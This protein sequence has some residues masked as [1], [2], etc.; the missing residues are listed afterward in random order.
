LFFRKDKLKNDF[1]VFKSFEVK[2]K[3]KTFILTVLGGFLL[4]F[5]WFLFMYAVNHVSLQSASFAYLI[6]PIIT[7]ILAFFILKE[8]LSKWQWFSVALCLVSC[9]ILSYGHIQDLAYS[10]IIAST[11][12]LYL[13]SQRKNNQFDRFVVLTVQMVIASLVLL[14]FFPTYKG[15]TPTASLFYILMTLI[16][17]LFTIIPLFLNLY[18][19]KGMNSSTVGILMYTNPLIN[20]ILAIYYFKE[21][22]NTSQMIAYSLILLSIIVFNE[23]VLFKRK[24]NNILK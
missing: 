9:G 4:T 5:N 17:I 13:I 16:V 7:T 2:E 23:S 8:K 1:Q 3:R 19:L 11:F 24:I 6:C 21:E 10:L 15:V 20:F 12:A 14:P 22:I 18:A